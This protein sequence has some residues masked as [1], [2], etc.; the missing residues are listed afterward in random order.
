MDLE[1]VGIQWALQAVAE[2]AS[3][4]DTRKFE[5]EAS[6]HVRAELVPAIRAV[7]D[8]AI[9]LLGDVLARYDEPPQSG[10]AD[11]SGVFN[12]VFDE[13][14]TDAA[15]SN[16]AQRIADISFMARWELE[17][18]QQ[19]VAEAERRADEWYLFAECCSA[20]RR[21]IKAASG[22]ERV[23][24]EVE[25]RPSMFIGLYQTEKQRAV[26]TR[27][28][29]Q[30]FILGLRQAER[31][32][33]L[34]LERYLRLVGTGIA[35]LVGRPIYE[36]LRVEDRR[37]LRAL[38][39]RVCQWLREPRNLQAGQRLASDVAAFSS[40][41]MEVNRRPAMIEY[42]QEVLEK[43]LGAVAQPATDKQAFY[44][45]LFT[46]RGR[47]PELDWLIEAR[48]DLSPE[49]WDA[50]ARQVLTQLRTLVNR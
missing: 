32:R 5:I 15:P 23:L 48:A 13:L 6:G 10:G 8:D 9:A 30:S 45:L 14:V 26:E 27:A 1:V 17:R 4:I 50:V 2:A 33:A 18:K 31:W 44:R 25:G 24:S 19:A 36:E 12:C 49:I 21:V 41:L 7:M 22:V 34:D 42:D 35:R 47:D 37:S 40:L 28:A 46:I 20:R 43:L 29:Y 39:A 3:G 11:D 38:Q 16:P